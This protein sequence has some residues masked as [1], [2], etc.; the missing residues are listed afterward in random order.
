MNPH[1]NPETGMVYRGREDLVH[2]QDGY[3]ADLGALVASTIDDAV[4]T[5]AVMDG[6]D[7]Y[8]DVRGERAK[9]LCPGCYMTILFNAARDLAI[10]NGQSLSELG[11]TL[12]HQ[13]GK[14]VNGD[15]G[16][17]EEVEVILDDEAESDDALPGAVNDDDVLGYLAGFEPNARDYGIVTFPSTVGM[18]AGEVTA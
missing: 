18:D 15:T 17:V 9:R 16:A 10:A 8:E 12:A 11:R 2:V 6:L 3:R 14:L 4:R 13:F 1:R 5:D 7:T